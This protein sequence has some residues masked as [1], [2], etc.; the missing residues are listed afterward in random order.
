MQ[1]ESKRI[2]AQA[3]EQNFEMYEKARNYWMIGLEEAGDRYQ[4][5]MEITGDG[6]KYQLVGKNEDGFEVYETSDQIKEMTQKEK[7]A[8]LIETIK[9]TYDGKKARFEK[10]GVTYQAELDRK[11]LRKGIYGDKKSD[12]SGYRAK[13]NIGADGGYFDLIENAN[14]KKSSNEKGKTTS[15]KAHKDVDGWDYYGKTIVSDGT[16]YDVLINIRDAGEKQYVYDVTLKATKKQ[17][18]QAARP[19]PAYGQE[20][21]VTNTISEA[22]EKSNTRFQSEDQTQ[23]AGENQNNKENVR[24]QLKNPVEETKYLIAVH[25]LNEE[26]IKN[27]R[28]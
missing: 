13:L 16:Q 10:D 27:I 5:G 3:L 4:S 24:F 12:R 6:T 15:N 22:E 8:A 19:K 21:P 18:P 17:N 1:T 23:T 2:E 20:N 11:G 26:I 28:I 9:K 14:Y 7:K 25:N